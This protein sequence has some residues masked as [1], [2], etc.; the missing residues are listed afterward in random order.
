MYLLC[1]ILRYQNDIFQGW[2]DGDV[3]CVIKMGGCESEREALYMLYLSQLPVD[4][5]I[6]APNLNQTC[7]LRS[8]T[9]LEI[10]GTESMPPMSFPRQSGN[11]TMHTAASYAERELS[12][13]LYEDTG[14]YRNQQFA[15]ADAITLQTTY[16]EIF[17]LWD[18]E[19]KYR[20][21]FSAGSQ[22]VNMPVIYAKIS[23][24]EDGKLA[25]YWQKVKSL[26]STSD[27]LLFRQ[28]PIMRGCGSSFGQ[29]AVKCLKDGRVRSDELKTNR[30]YPFGLLR[31]EMQ[32]H[33][34]RKTQG[35]LDERLIRG[36]FENGTEYTV[37][38]TILGMSKEI[39]RLIRKIRA[40]VTLI[41]LSCNRRLYTPANSFSQAPA[42]I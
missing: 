22:G 41:P 26:V 30:Q 7:V 40:D 9:L 10:T 1:W 35:M 18:Q 2:R 6:F 11:L 28:F 4:V 36:T 12:S 29:L 24:V 16:D 21:N 32:E 15:R 38:S 39:L 14:L 20:P 27:T 23:G 13:V 8:D 42:S 17:I 34:L 5:I 19:L 3:L 25:P 33:I 31:G 37:L